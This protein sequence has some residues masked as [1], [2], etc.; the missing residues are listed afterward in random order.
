[1]SH[2]LI[3]D[4]NM[5]ICRAIQTRLEALGFASFDHAWTE[6]QAVAAAAARIPDLVVVGDEIAEGRSLDAAKLIAEQFAVPV[7]LVTGD[8]DRARRIAGKECLF[9]G[10]FLIN[11]IEDAV[12]LTR[13][14]A[15]F[16]C[17]P[18]LQRG[19]QRL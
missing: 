9:E 12:A 19:P 17:T 16:R 11:Q 4:D 8:V 18:S 14:D 6:R 3:I 2:A 13:C 7:L 10:P 1:M 5:I 15:P